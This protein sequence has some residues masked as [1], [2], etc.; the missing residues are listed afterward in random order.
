MVKLLVSRGAE[1]DVKDILFGG[2]PLDWAKH[3]GKTEVE[4]FLRGKTA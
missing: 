1:T 2:T 3:G 4:E